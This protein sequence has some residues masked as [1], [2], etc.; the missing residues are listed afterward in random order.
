[1]ERDAI[2]ILF[3]DFFEHKM[4]YQVRRGNR[5]K[6]GSRADMKKG[7]LSDAFLFIGSICGRMQHLVAQS[8][9]YSLRS[10]FFCQDLSPHF[11]HFIYLVLFTCMAKKTLLYA[12]T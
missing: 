7:I 10:T 8:P 1:M 2:F 11:G 4:T 3:H 9:H 5:N 12:G 6:E